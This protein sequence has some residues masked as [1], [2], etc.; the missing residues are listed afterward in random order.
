[1]CVRSLVLLY[2]RN[3]LVFFNCKRQLWKAQVL[4]AKLQNSVALV[5]SPVGGAAEWSTVITRFLAMIYDNTVAGSEYSAANNNMIPK[6]ITSYKYM[7]VLLC[8]HGI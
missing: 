6:L 8:L 3:R 7:T 4:S 5:N 1:M 2:F